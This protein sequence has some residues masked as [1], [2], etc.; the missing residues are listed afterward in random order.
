MDFQDVIDQIWNLPKLIHLYWDLYFKAGNYSPIP[1]FLSTSLQYLTICKNKWYSNQFLN[2]LEKT[3]RLR[4]LSMSLDTYEED[5]RPLAHEFMPSSK[6]V[7][8]TKLVLSSIRSQRLMTNLFQLLSNV[9]HLKASS[10]IR[11]LDLQ[12]HDLSC[13][14]HRYD[15]KRCIEL[16]RLPLDIQCGILIIEVEK[17]ECIL[18]LIYSMINLRIWKISYKYDKFSNKYD[19]VEVLEQYLP[20]T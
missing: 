18:K 4:K 2:L 19:L 5:D 9:I 7:L 10:S 1:K 15:I 6:N 16:S 13:R 20:S 11:L 12:G 8:I 14:H 3:P 17:P